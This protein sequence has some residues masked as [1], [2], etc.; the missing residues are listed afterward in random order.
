MKNIHENIKSYGIYQNKVS[1]KERNVGDNLW[2]TINISAA[3]NVKKGIC[4]LHVVNF[5]PLITWCY[6]T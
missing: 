4:A 3:I 6:N 1:D 5:S 2:S